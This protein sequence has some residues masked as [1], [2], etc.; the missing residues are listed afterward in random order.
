MNMNM[1]LPDGGDFHPSGWSTFD[2]D[3]DYV[4]CWPIYQN[5]LYYIIQ[6]SDEICVSI[7]HRFLTNQRDSSPKQFEFETWLFLGFQF[8][9]QLIQNEA[10]NIFHVV[11]L[12]TNTPNMYN[13][14]LLHLLLLNIVVV[15][16]AD[17][18][19]R[20]ELG[21]AGRLRFTSGKVG[22]KFEYNNDL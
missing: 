19:V 10:F 2:I 12:D 21:V 15:V 7:P 14:A 1:G 17:K 11:H 22:S 6:L 5:N 20:E 9:K 13:S 4:M 8:P 18:F 3:F 16:V